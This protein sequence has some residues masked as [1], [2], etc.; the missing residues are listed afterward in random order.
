[1]QMTKEKTALIP[2]VGANGGQSSQIYNDSIP[3]SSEK[4]N[5]DFQ[6]S[7][8]LGK[9]L[10]EMQRAMDPRYFH[11]KTMSELYQTAYKG[12]PSLIEGLLYEGVY[13]LAGA[14]KIG[15]SFL[16]AQLAY[17]IGTGAPLWGF[18]CHQGTVLYLALED[19]FQRLQSRMFMM[20]GTN[21]TDKLHFDIPARKIGGG[22]E[23]Q[24]QNFIR[25]YKD[26]RLIIIDTLQK[27]REVGGDAYSYANDYEI[28][29]KLKEFAD[30]N[31][32]C[33][34]VVQTDLW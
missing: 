19:D 6:I 2:F 15:K 17:H 1:M 14:P 29:G 33:I 7:D 9:K 3:D 27:I 11:T 5:G 30:N 16:V 13:I 12:R 22:L 10:K 21:A 25:D 32:I 26:T 24:M 18:R 28:I 8:D 34:L 23:E 4:N 20:Y 31:G